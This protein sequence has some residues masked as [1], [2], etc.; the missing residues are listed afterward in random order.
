MKT[1]LGKVK[2]VCGKIITW[3]GEHADLICAVLGL[4]TFFVSEITKLI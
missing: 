3:I 2:E 1:F 4:C